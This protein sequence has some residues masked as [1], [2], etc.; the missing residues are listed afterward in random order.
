MRKYHSMETAPR[1]GRDIILL[2][3]DGTEEIAGYRDCEWIREANPG[4][5]VPDCWDGYQLDDIEL[6]V[7]RGWRELQ[8]N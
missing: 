3:P 2:M 1:D 5:N 6:D 7:P 4:E 8:P